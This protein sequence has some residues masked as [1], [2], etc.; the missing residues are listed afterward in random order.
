MGNHKAAL[1][2]EVEERRIRDA[3]C[4]A[5]VPLVTL[6][7]KT[8]GGSSTEVAAKYVEKSEPI[9]V[10]GLLLSV[11]RRD[12]GLVEVRL[13]QGSGSVTPNRGCCGSR[14]APGRAP[15]PPRTCRSARWAS[16][17]WTPAGSRRAAAGARRW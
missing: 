11:L 3:G 9:S 14:P 10:T 8:T 15:G 5:V 13:R 4:L 7:F 1:R 16:S 6:L 17:S 2:K 12:D